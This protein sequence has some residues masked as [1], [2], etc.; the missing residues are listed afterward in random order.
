MRLETKKFFD[1]Q[2]AASLIAQFVSEKRLE[3]YRAGALLR[4]V[5]EPQVQDHWRGPHATRK[6]G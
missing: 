4:S 5:V 2:R 1:I 3:D 6:P